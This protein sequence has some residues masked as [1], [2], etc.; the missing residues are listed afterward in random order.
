MLEVRKKKSGRRGHSSGPTFKFGL[1]RWHLYV[2]YLAAAGLLVA[3][4]FA[5]LTSIP[6]DDTNKVMI[7]VGRGFVRDSIR[8]ELKTSFAA[9]EETRVV[10]LPENKFMIT[11]WVDVLNEVGEVSRQNFSCVIFKNASDDWVGE[12]ISVMPQEM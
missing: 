9:D 4:G 7:G 11:G 1:R 5:V 6:V 8:E 3:G 2:L 12:K 10:A